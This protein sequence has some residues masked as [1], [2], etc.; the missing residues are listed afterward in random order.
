MN[1]IITDNTKL[2]R[3]KVQIALYDSEHVFEEGVKNISSWDQKQ[4]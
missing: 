4:L 3:Q 2:K 1:V